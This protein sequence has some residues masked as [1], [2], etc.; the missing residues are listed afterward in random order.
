DRPG[1]ATGLAIMGFGGGAMIASP[2]SIFLMNHFKSSTN[3]GVEQTFIVMG[4]LYFCFM[5]FGVIT[6]R[7]PPENWKPAGYTAPTASH[8]LITSRNIEVGTAVRTPQFYLLWLVL[9]LNV[10]AGIGILEQASPMIQEMFSGKVTAAAAGGFVG[11]L[12]LFNMLGRFFW[13]STSD[14]IG[15]KPTYMI[16]F[17]LGALLYLA[18]R[19]TGDMGSVPLFVACCVLI[20]SMYGGG[21]ATI[22]AYIKDLFGTINVS[23][24]HGRVLTAWSVAG[25]L[26][27]VVV[28][29]IRD[30]QKSHGVTGVDVYSPIFYVMA[31]LLVIGFICNLMVR[32]VSDDVAQ[33]NQ[34]GAKP[35]HA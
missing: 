12:S 21:F 24:I 30:Y 11:V 14:F 6:I 33:A 20:L 15:R 7:I 3:I 17:A 8:G 1:M 10:T 27:P 31:G 13:S 23:A 28:N 35:A 9:C 25:V 34:S 32:P 4:I 2:L 18:L 29:S 26:G 5:M 19:F 16:F 22:P